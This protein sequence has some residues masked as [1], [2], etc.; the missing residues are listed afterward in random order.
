M[1]GFKQRLDDGVFEEVGAKQGL[2]AN[3]LREVA[4]SLLCDEA[5]FAK[6]KP[7]MQ[8]KVSQHRFLSEYAKHRGAVATIVGEDENVAK[9]MALTDEGLPEAKRQEIRE[10]AARLAEVMALTEEEQ[11]ARYPEEE[12]AKIRVLREGRES[13][14]LR[15]WCL[16]HGLISHQ[17][18]DDDD[19]EPVLVEVP[20]EPADDFLREDDIDEI[21]VKDRGAYLEVALPF[22]AYALETDGAAPSRSAS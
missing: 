18:D 5:R 20:D 12:R 19:E 2:D 11:I 4:R 10:G 7:S 21:F 22:Q 3:E 8:T 13:A 14:A 15:G 17:D 1:V 9:I 16:A 6:L